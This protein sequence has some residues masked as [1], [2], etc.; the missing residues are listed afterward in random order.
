MDLSAFDF[1]AL[2]L[3]VAAAA[4]ITVVT[5]YAARTPGWRRLLLAAG[6]LTIVLGALALLDLLREQP[7]E[8]HVA[9]VIVGALLPSFGAIVMQRAGRR[10]RPWVRWTLVFVTAFCLLF[11]GLLIGAAFV[12]RFL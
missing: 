3:G 5:S 4:V 12:P 1:P 6:I 8:T 9:T 7:R 2:L 10:L 11:A